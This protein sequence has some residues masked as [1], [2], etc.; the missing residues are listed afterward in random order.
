MRDLPIWSKLGL[1]MLVPTLATIVVGVE[2]L[3]GHISTASNAERARTLAVLSESA[4]NLVDHLQNERAYAV[5]IATSKDKNPAVHD[6]AVK[7]FNAETGQV[8]QARTAYEQQ[9][10]SLDNVPDKVNTLLSRI[11]NYLDDLKNTRPQAADGGLKLDG[12]QST[13]TTIV[14]DLISVREDSAQLAVNT[15]LSDHLRTVAALA[16]A[17]EYVAQQRDVGNLIVSGGHMTSS[18][19]RQFTQTETGFALASSAL[20]T[21]GS[22]SEL[23]DFQTLGREPASRWSATWPS[24]S[25]TCRPRPTRSRSPPTSGIRR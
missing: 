5:I 18:L 15:A 25:T 17:K 9:K 16:Q 10:I 11:D 8:D 22:E 14:G 4:G 2:G 1:I 21:V 13:Y 7:S 23:K 24:R 19:R 6:A 3:V 12:L 20:Q